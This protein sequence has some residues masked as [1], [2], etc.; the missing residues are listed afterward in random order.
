MIAD[1]LAAIDRE[2][3]QALAAAHTA[4]DLERVKAFFLGRK[5]RLNDLFKMF[6]RLPAEQRAACGQQVNEL[7]NRLTASLEL[8]IA[9]CCAGPSAAAVSEIDVSLP[10]VSR[11]PGGTHP[12]T[13]VLDEVC[14]LFVE[15]GFSVVEGPE[16]E[17]EYYNFEALNIPLE[18]P[19]RDGFDTFYLAGNYLLRS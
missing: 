3:G 8:K 17:T 12:L 10:G 7:K 11:D 18:H 2:F 9:E 13:Q 4:A 14:S 15:M 16:I 6:A 19:S 5:G 1:Q